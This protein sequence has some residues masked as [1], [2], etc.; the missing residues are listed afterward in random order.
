MKKFIAVIL[1]TF[2]TLSVFTSCS[3]EA[4]TLMDFLGSGAIELDLE[5]QEIIFIGET[6]AEDALIDNQVKVNTTLYDCVLGRFEEIN[7]RYNCKI[8]YQT[9]AEGAKYEERFN[10]II[11]AGG[12][13][14]DIIYGNSDSKLQVFTEAGFLTPLTSVKE[15]LDYEDSA[16]FGSAG[17]LE[18][19][20]VNGIP[21]AVQPCYWPGFQNNYDYVLVYNPT[22]VTEQGL[23]NLHEYYENE[24]WTWDAFQ[25]IVENFNN[26]GEE[27]VYAT[28]TVREAF[29]KM[30][31]ASNGVKGVDYIDGVLKSDIST[32]KAIRAVEWMQNILGNNK[33]NVL[34][35]ED[36]ELDEF[37]N[38]QTMTALTS[39]PNLT[40]G[41]LQFE[42]NIQFNIMPFPCGPDGAYGEWAQYTASIRGLAIPA[43]STNAE[44]SARIISDLCE[45]FEDFGGSAG[46]TDYFN[47]NVFFDP[48]DTEIY[49][50]LGD[51]IRYTYW[52]TGVNLQTL[53]A[54]V[55]KRYESAS[56]V[57]LLTGFEPQ[58][59]GFI[60]T[61]LKANFENYLYDHLYADK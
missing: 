46:L 25:P 58:L 28:M 57:E 32:P 48:I 45:P 43:S 1:L 18:A 22:M 47:T 21:H 44:A 41:K 24:N 16:K 61:L 50:S 35:K 27:E 14:G 20:M 59:Q 3:G 4:A 26:A 54:E 17:L 8:S 37:I 55:A 12:C 51:N 53:F 6:F 15:Y 56:A 31:L 52:R 23:P 9:F 40:A 39:T 2:M 5:G 60:D 29:V 19:A 42:S 11:Y 36:W 30:A 49:L 33:E 7:K 13:P 10:A 34:L 38:G